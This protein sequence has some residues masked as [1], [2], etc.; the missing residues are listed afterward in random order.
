MTRGGAQDDKRGALRRTRGAQVDIVRLLRVV[1]FTFVK[2][3]AD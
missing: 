1:V 3:A 2:R